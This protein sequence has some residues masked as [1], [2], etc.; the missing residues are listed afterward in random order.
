MF[1]ELGG[2]GRQRQVVDAGQGGDA[3][4]QADDVAPQQGLAAG[5]ADAAYAQA[6]KSPDQAFDFVKGE[7]VLGFFK[8]LEAF[9]DAVAA[10]QVA[11]I[12]DGQSHVIDAAV[13]LI[14]EHG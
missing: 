14:G 4:G 11:P 9:R 12:G 7:P 1:V 3:P 2:V 6:G 13:E 5:H 10:A 8:A